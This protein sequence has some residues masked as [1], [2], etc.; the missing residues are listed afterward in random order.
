MRWRVAQ[1]V[2]CGGEG[3]AGEPSAGSSPLL[4]TGSKNQDQMTTPDKL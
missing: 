4:V 3:K 2:A 1:Q